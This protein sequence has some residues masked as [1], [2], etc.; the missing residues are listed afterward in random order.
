MRSDYLLLVQV[1]PPSAEH[2]RI[3][4]DAFENGVLSSAVIRA[5]IDTRDRLDRPLTVGGAKLE[6]M[7]TVNGTQSALEIVDRDDGRCT[8]NNCTCVC[9]EYAGLSI[10]GAQHPR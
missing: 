10:S 6:A 9:F 8:Q 3:E 5:S 4:I 7:L 1:L 2:T